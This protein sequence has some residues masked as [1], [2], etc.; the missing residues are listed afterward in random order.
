MTC[1]VIMMFTLIRISL[2]DTYSNSMADCENLIS[3]FYP[4]IDSDGFPTDNRDQPYETIRCQINGICPDGVSRLSCTWMRYLEL[5]C[6][7]VNS[8]TQIVVITNNMPDHCYFN[9]R[10]QNYPTAAADFARLHKYKFSANFNVHPSDTVVAQG[11]DDIQFWN[12]TIINDQSV[13]DYNLCNYNLFKSSLIDSSISY[14]E[15][16]FT[17]TYT[18]PSWE[19]DQINFPSN[20]LTNSDNI[21][22]VALNGVFLRNGASDLQFDGFFP[23]LY[24]T[25]SLFKYF[26]TDVCLGTSETYNSYS[27]HMYSPCM[28]PSVQIKTIVSSCNNELYPFCKLQ[29]EKHIKTYTPSQVKTMVPIGIARDGRVIYGPF[30]SDGDLWQPCD[31]DICNG[32]YFT[33][34][35]Y[36]YVATMF[37]PYLIGC[38]GPANAPNLQP[39][40]TSNPRV[41][42]QSS[43]LE[44]YPSILMFSSIML[45]ILSGNSF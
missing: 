37:H 21:V 3:N 40:C 27:Y 23:K 31:V 22:G 8:V 12:M 24:G 34:N 13:L 5:Q 28:Y 18:Q 43:F 20:R 9:E 25:K 45:L 10:D 7:Q 16:L 36:G 38:W 42:L 15:S 33:G 19:L 17:S 30:R 35:Y 4:T 1:F 29:P 2:C 11:K 39:S 41:C 26:Q 32:R 44:V 14:S 6:Q